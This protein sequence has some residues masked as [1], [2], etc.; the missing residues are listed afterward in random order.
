MARDESRVVL[1]SLAAK[2]PKTR[3]RGRL[4]VSQFSLDGAR[5]HIVGYSPRGDANNFGETTD[6]FLVLS[7]NPPI[8]GASF[9]PAVH[10]VDFVVLIESDVHPWLWTPVSVGDDGRVRLEGVS[11]RYVIV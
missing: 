4:A 2:A 10:E 5:L 9:D 7:S 1:E 8:L 11:E 3:R 6:R